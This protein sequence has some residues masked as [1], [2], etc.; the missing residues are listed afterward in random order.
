MRYAYPVDLTLQDDGRVLARFPDLVGA[1]TDGATRAEAL[2]EAADCLDMALAGLL[3]DGAD[4]PPPSPAAG[5]PLVAV[6]PTTAAKVA[7]H[8]RMRSL[9][10]SKVELAR[11]LG[12]P[13]PVVRRMLHPLR[14]TRTERLVQALAVLGIQVEVHTR[15][16][17]ARV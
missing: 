11:R 13:E 17:E 14:Q 12:V 5:R 3:L 15:L 16:A 4:I 8:E 10:I 1:V 6:E 9:G 2:A 7:L